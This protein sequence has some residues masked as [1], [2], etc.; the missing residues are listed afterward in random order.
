MTIEPVPS[1]PPIRPNDAD[2]PT[3]RSLRRAVRRQLSQGAMRSVPALAVT[4][5][6]SGKSIVLRQA[7]SK[8][9]D[10]ILGYV[11]PPEFQ[12]IVAVAESVVSSGSSRHREATLAVA[13]SRSG[14]EV[15]FLDSAGTVTETFQPQGWLID[16]CRRAVSLPTRP[17]SAHPLE[18]PLALW[19]DRIMVEVL[20]TQTPLTWAAALSLCPVPSR[21]ISDRS[22]HLGATLASITPTWSAAR[23]GAANGNPLPV[24]MVSAHAA[25]MDDAMFARWCLGYF[26]DLAEL[27]SDIEFLAPPGVAAQVDATIR[28]AYSVFAQ[29]CGGS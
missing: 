18:L 2:T 25:W 27:R 8:P 16:A 9:A 26:P 15:C 23:S 20:Q 17:E 22:E 3:E 11:L 14:Q 13:V 4:G 6:R 7:H 24:P 10:A 29:G 28:C 5:I 19:L 12:A 21:W 1:R